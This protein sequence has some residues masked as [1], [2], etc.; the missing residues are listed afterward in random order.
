MNTVQVPDN[1]NAAAFFVDRHIEEGRADKTAVFCGDAAYTYRQVHEKVNRFANVLKLLGVRME[2]RVAILAPDSIDTNTFLK[3]QEFEYILNDSRARVLVVSQDLLPMIEEVRK[4]LLYLEHVIVIGR[5]HG[6][7]GSFDELLA[8]ASPEFQ[9]APTSK[10]DAAFWL[11]SSGTTGFPKGAVHLHHDMVVS[12][13]L[14]AGQV[15]GIRE[16]DVSYSVAKLFFAYGLGNGLYFPFRVGGSTV[17]FGGRPVPEKVFDI[18]EKYHPTIFYSVPTSYAGLLQYAEQTGRK[19]LGRVRLCVSAGEALPK[20]I[21]ERWLER[22]G[23]EILDGIGTTEILHIF[24]S[25]RPGKARPGSTGQVVPGYEAR[26]VDEDGNDVGPGQVG[27][28]MIKGDSIASTYWNRHEESKKTFVGE[29][30]RTGDKY[31]RD[32]DGYFWYAGR[33]DDMFKM[34]G[35]WVSPIEIENILIEHPAVLESG[36]VGIPD[37]NDLVKAKAFVVLRKG[38]EPSQDL[39]KELQQFVK[40]RTAVYKYPRSI[41][42]VDSLPKTATGK[43]QRFKLREQ[44]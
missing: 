13:D 29:W 36:V 7:Y 14:Y 42:F 16:S 26:I 10:D 18:I 34:S 40:S 11:Y 24:I 35:Y 32:E 30:I 44:E 33:S 12:A 27:N 41:E 8:G 17:L 39:A 9:A 37:E 22:F 21:Y 5:A 1:F 28:L 6:D 2:E 43:I 15:L 25:N 38:H 23:I 19:S 31:M 3:A 4:N 20:S